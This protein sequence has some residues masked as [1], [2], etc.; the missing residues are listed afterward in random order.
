MGC[1]KIIPE[2]KEKM[3]NYMKIKSNIIEKSKGILNIPTI[4]QSSRGNKRSTYFWENGAKRKK[5]P[6]KTV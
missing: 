4:T 6:M 5:I 2:A 1:E 3:M